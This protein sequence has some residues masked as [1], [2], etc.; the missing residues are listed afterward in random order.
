[1]DS[2]IQPWRAAKNLLFG[3]GNTA[4]DEMHLT[5][6]AAMLWSV[7]CRSGQPPAKSNIL[8]TRWFAGERIQLVIAVSINDRSMS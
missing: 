6:N 8:T 7:H 3:I 5:M 2:L 4:C 1:M